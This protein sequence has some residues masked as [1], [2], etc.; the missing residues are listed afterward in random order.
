MRLPF[1]LAGVLTATAVAAVPKDLRLLEDGRIPTS[2]SLV[3][4]RQTAYLEAVGAFERARRT[5]QPVRGGACEPTFMGVTTGA[6]TKAN[7]KQT[8]VVYSYCDEYAGAGS[9]NFQQAVGILENDQLVRTIDLNEET[10]GFLVTSVRDV[11]RNGFSELLLTWGGAWQGETYGELNLVELGPR[12]PRL[13]KTF[14]DAWSNCA[15]DMHL[16]RVE[17]APVYYVRPG[18]RPTFFVEVYERPCL[19][20]TAS[21]DRENTAPYRRTTALKALK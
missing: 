3:G 2:F 20:I 16:P 19:P 12:G 1:M 9:T 15:Q 14:D 10:R 17:R 7:V 13:L 8:A 21:G 6:F 11:N 5:R 4:F 18:T